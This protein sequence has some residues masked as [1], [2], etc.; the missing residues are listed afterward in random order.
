MTSKSDVHMVGAR[1]SDLPPVTPATEPGENT[2]C[3]LISLMQPGLVSHN[4]CTGKKES[5]I[6]RREEDFYLKN[7]A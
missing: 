7:L 2:I 5:H 6:M 1:P 4:M 3:Q